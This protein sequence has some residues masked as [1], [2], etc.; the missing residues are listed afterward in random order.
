MTNRIRAEQLVLSVDSAAGY[1]TASWE[2]GKMRVSQQAYHHILAKVLL[3]GAI[4]H[5]GIKYV[6]ATYPNPKTRLPAHGRFIVTQTNR[7]GLVDIVQLAKL[8]KKAE[9]HECGPQEA[10]RQNKQAEQGI[11]GKKHGRRL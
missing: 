6:H 9:N 2:V 11:A 4:K 1:G 7:G 3:L 10:T 8:L 5:I